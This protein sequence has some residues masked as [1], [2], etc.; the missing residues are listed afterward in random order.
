MLVLAVHREWLDDGSQ[1]C[2]AFCIEVQPGDGPLP[3]A[4]KAA[5]D[6]RRGRGADID[7]R[8]V[9]AEDGFAV[10]ARLRAARKALT[11]RDGMPL[12]A[13]CSNEQLAAMVTGH[14]ASLA[15][16]VGALHR[17][18]AAC[19]RGPPGRAVAGAN[20]PLSP[21]LVVA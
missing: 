4:L 21:R 17:S 20:A 15:K 7:Y 8:Q 5:H 13:V 10:Y 16:Q 19:G 3:D 1:S 9:L 11:Q 14:G 2:W 6:A 18:F 12:Y